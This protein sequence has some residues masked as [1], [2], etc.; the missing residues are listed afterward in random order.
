MAFETSYAIG[1]AVALATHFTLQ[2]YFVWSHHEEFA[3]PIHHQFVRY[4]PVALA[5]YGL[6]ALAIAVL[7]RA[8]DTSS[9]LVYLA[10]TAVVT[11]GSFLIFRGGVFHA[12]DAPEGSS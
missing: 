9:L 11:L 7:P 6:V 8:L 4:L 2:R 1:Y 5:N 10:A 12:E 3:L